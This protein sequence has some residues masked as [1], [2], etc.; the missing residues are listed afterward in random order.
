M[1]EAELASAF[2]IS[3]Y[4]STIFLASD[5]EPTTVFL[6]YTDTSQFPSVLSFIAEDH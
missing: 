1:T 4:R 2:W 5:G 6:G 3:G